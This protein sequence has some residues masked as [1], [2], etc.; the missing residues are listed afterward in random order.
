MVAL[1]RIYNNVFF[2]NIIL[3]FA[4]FNFALICFIIK[5]VYFMFSDL[6]VYFIC[7]KVLDCIYNHILTFDFI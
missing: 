2:H 3:H 4:Y 5:Y 7:L 6:D 1:V